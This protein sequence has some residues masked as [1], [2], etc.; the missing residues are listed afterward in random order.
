MA[1]GVELVAVDYRN[2]CHT[3]QAPDRV[4]A[5]VAVGCIADCR[6]RCCIDQAL[7]H[8]AV[9]GIPD[10]CIRRR[11]QRRSLIALKCPRPA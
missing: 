6:T 8:T 4:A 7:D 11:D 1:E 3:D 2:R 9:G 10:F 5:V